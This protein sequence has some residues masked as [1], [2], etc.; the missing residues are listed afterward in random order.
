MKAALVNANASDTFLLRDSVSCYLSGDAYGDSAML[1]DLV[2]GK[3]ITQG[4]MNSMMK[5]LGA[6]NHSLWTKD[7]IA[8]AVVLQSATLPSSALSAKKATKAWTKYFESQKHGFYEV[9]K[10][11]F[12]LDGKSAVVYTAFQCGAKCGNGGA[13]LFQWKNDKWVPVK[14]LYSWR[15]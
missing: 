12:S 4:D 3:F 2:R 1:Q 8:G 11:L 13:T 5:Q 6:N 10:P 9:G 14:N 15:K 7:S